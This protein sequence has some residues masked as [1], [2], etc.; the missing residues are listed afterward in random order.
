MGSRK[1]AT[2]RGGPFDAALSVVI[3]APPLSL[4]LTGSPSGTVRVAAVLL[5]QE[6]A[7]TAIGSNTTAIGGT[8]R[9]MSSFAPGGP[10]VRR[11]LERSVRPP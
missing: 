9:V 6:Q 10:W 5:Q 1:E 7:S 8:Q 3:S 4:T 11:C 2:K